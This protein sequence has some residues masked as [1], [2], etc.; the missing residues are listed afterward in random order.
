MGTAQF[1]CI[2]SSQNPAFFSPPKVQITK[3]HALV[4]QCVDLTDTISLPY[5]AAEPGAIGNKQPFPWQRDLMPLRLRGMGGL[6]KETSPLSRSSGKQPG[7]HKKFRGEAA[8]QTKRKHSDVPAVVRGQTDCVS[9]PFWC[10]W[11]N[12]VPLGHQSSAQ[13]CLAP[14]CS[15][16]NILR[17]NKRT[18]SKPSSIAEVPPNIFLK[19]VCLGKDLAKQGDGVPGA[20]ELCYLRFVAMF[21]TE[22]RYCGSPAW[23]SAPLAPQARPCQCP[24]RGEFVPSRPQAWCNPAPGARS[25][26]HKHQRTSAVLTGA[27]ARA[28]V[29][30]A[31]GW[32][33]QPPL[34]LCC[35]SESE[36]APASWQ[37]L[38][39]VLSLLPR[40]GRKTQPWD[41]S[42]QGDPTACPCH[43][44]GHQVPPQYEQDRK[45][46]KR[47]Q[48]RLSEEGTRSPL[49]PHYW[50]RHK[51]TSLR[52]DV[53]EGSK[54]HGSTSARLCQPRKQLSKVHGGKNVCT[55]DLHT[56][57][58]NGSIPLIYLTP[59]KS[60]FLCWY[61]FEE[62]CSLKNR[63]RI[64]RCPFK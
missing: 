36:R 41:A 51:K 2:Q 22:S 48:F 29:S 35:A 33:E 44:Q 57:Q 54:A 11:Y 58:A 56:A 16:Y 12:L 18:P 7:W 28:Y 42:R 8:K 23:Q 53:W 43:H 13:H 52:T 20:A 27:R 37:G 26:L 38:S 30:A 4:K 49:L 19:L 50:G 45:L 34:P 5:P 14:Q 60:I 59:S 40:V 25:S 32:A 61:S 55:R 15:L 46:G 10:P 24:G 31:P 62:C 1:K 47:E 64:W 63:Y 6:S 3:V 21:G 39:P 9:L 17:L